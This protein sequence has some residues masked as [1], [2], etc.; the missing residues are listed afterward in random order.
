V[1]VTPA[2]VGLV[3]VNRSSKDRHTEVDDRASGF[4]CWRCAR[5]GCKAGPRP[6]QRRR[7][8]GAQERKG[9]NI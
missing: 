2:P 4:G 3:V 9:P 7:P 6:M 5:R 1:P 8:P